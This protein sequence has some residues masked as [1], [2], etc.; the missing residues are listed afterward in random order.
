M[1]LQFTIAIHIMNGTA[2]VLAALAVPSHNRKDTSTMDKPIMTPI[3]VREK[4]GRGKDGSVLNEYRCSQCGAIRVQKAWEAARY[5]KCR[6][7]GRKRHGF[8]RDHRFT[9][10][11][12]MKQ[13][14]TN[15]ANTS[16]ADYK[17]R[18]IGI[19]DEWLTF[20]GFML[21]EK[22]NEWKPGLQIDR[23][24]NDLGYSPENCRWVTCSE[25]ARNRRTTK[26]TDDNVRAVRMLCWSGIKRS[27]V[28][29]IFGVS[30]AH[31]GRVMRFSVG[32]DI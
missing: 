5:T 12:N 2:A 8:C 1:R 16:Y 30:P 23:I 21:W 14:V 4:V 18:G 25:N 6:S 15:D 29:K 19:C 24:N 11:V 17:G 3:L 28:A 20:E 27:D 22:F 13:R 26:L 32:G 7:C 9:V 10:W 31:I